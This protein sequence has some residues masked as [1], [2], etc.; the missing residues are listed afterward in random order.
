MVLVRRRP[1]VVIRVIVPHV[2]V[3]VQRRRRGRRH[4]KGLSKQECDQSAHGSSVLRPAGTLRK[5]RRVSQ[6][7]EWTGKGSVE[8][9]TN[10][11]REPRPRLPRLGQVTA[12]GKV[13]ECDIRRDQRQHHD[14]RDPCA[15]VNSM[16]LYDSHRRNREHEVEAADADGAAR[17]YWKSP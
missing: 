2:L 1:V 12:K 17:L 13:K 14:Y 6:L 8:I 5:T 15:A 11:I 16:S 7:G 10:S 9:A 3:D 4:D